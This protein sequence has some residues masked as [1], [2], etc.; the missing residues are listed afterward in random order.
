MSPGATR[1]ALVVWAGGT[2]IGVDTVGLR[3]R[4]S[5][6]VNGG[7]DQNEGKE[8]KERIGRAE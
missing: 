3:S 8:E 5:A 2:R 4:R 1:R 6:A 7:K